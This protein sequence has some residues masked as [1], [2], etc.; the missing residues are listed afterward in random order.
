MKLRLTSTG[1][2]QKRTTSKTPSNDKEQMTMQKLTTDNLKFITGGSNGGKGM[3]PKAQALTI[4]QL[5]KV[6]GGSGGGKGVD[7]KTQGQIKTVAG[8]STGYKGLASIAQT[9]TIDGLRAIGGGSGGHKGPDPK[10]VAFISPLGDAFDSSQKEEN[11][12]P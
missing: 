9:L 11:T 4:E 8:N 6:N 5:R 10:A 12:I 2:H 3:D 7:P 1:P